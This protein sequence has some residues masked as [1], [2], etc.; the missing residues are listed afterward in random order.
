M[1][2]S[3]MMQPMPSFVPLLWRFLLSLWSFM[4][5]FPH[6]CLVIW[7]GR[8]PSYFGFLGSICCYFADRPK[9]TWSMGA[10]N[11]RNLL[12]CRKPCDVIACC[13]SDCLL[14]CSVLSRGAT[15]LCSLLLLHM[16]L[17]RTLAHAPATKCLYGIWF[18]EALSGNEMLMDV[19]KKWNLGLYLVGSR[20]KLLFWST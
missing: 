1:M 12:L 17:A 18:I 6:I 2:D 4:S 14:V 5:R 10:Y 8:H 13:S 9:Q 7:L 11:S 19:G 3:I 20:K 15:W 16:P